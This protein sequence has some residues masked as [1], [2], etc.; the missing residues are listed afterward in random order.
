MN[1]EQIAAMSNRPAASRD[2]I[3]ALR[4]NSLVKVPEEYFELL[5][6]ANGLQQLSEPVDHPDQ[7]VNLDDLSDTLWIF[8]AE[9]FTK[10]NRSNNPVHIGYGAGIKAI[11]MRT[12][13]DV[14]T[15]FLSDTEY[16]QKPQETIV[17]G[18]NFFDAVTNTLEL[19][20][21]SNEG[22][23]PRLV[24]LPQSATADG[25]TRI[26]YPGFY[27][28]AYLRDATTLVSFPLC[29]NV[30][31][32]EAT[33][34]SV[35]SLGQHPD[36]PMTRDGEFA[37]V[38][39]GPP[40]F[41]Y[42]LADCSTGKYRQLKDFGTRPRGFAFDNSKTVL[43][44]Y[45]FNT[46][47]AV[48]IAGQTLSDPTVIYEVAKFDGKRLRI[49]G[50]A[51]QMTKLAFINILGKLKVYN[52]GEDRNLTLEFEHKEM[53]G[54]VTQLIFSSDTYLYSIGAGQLNCWD[55]GKQKLS[56]SRKGYSDIALDAGV[57]AYVENG[58]SLVSLLNA[59]TGEQIASTEIPEWKCSWCAISPDGKSVV[60]S[61]ILP[62][63][64]ATYH[65]DT[66]AY[67]EALSVK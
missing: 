5:S 22:R 4:G 10:Y 57:I 24:G 48:P 51:E 32:E 17:I 37:I 49:A 59:V 47:F 33:P 12:K 2:A 21:A 58:K 67:I 6:V 13:G 36:P 25:L 42:R 43:V 20:K 41:L 18:T 62:E 28:R 61:G 38:T 56:F 27:E 34:R 64:N 39:S 30:E 52:V 53:V 45:D 23:F 15:Y 26:E 16:G 66:S 14:Q 1:I 65:W 35:E 31:T 11:Y 8:S 55:L 19:G 7:L 9:E 40:D 44:A 3:E 63:A 60:A 46:V 29:F 50:I 54:R